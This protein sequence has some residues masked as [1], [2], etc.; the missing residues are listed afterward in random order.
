MSCL[1]GSFGNRINNSDLLPGQAWAPEVL[2]LPADINGTYFL[3]VGSDWDPKD[4]AAN[5][6]LNVYSGG[7]GGT[8]VSNIYQEY[9]F[10]SFSTSFAYDGPT[11]G[12]L[13]VEVTGNG[14]ANM[15]YKG[16]CLDLPNASDPTPIFEQTCFE[17]LPVCKCP[18]FLRWL[19][20]SGGWQYWTFQ[21]LKK[22][23]LSAERGAVQSIYE[24]LLSQREVI[25]QILTSSAE[26]VINLKAKG[27]K[28][29]HFDYLKSIAYAPH[30]LLL[31]NPE[32]WQT[33]GAQWQGVLIDGEQFV[34]DCDAGRLESTISIR[35]PEVNTVKNTV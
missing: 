30:V 32:T 18:T 29:W 20:P 8:L 11:N 27:L 14:I 3:Q 7:L 5:W 35:I 12:P 1:T 9:G 23:T 21:Y 19:N 16:D 22:T 26:D 6:T 2:T 15:F 28:K 4:P 13:T 31:K 17:V 24:P 34:K 33:E 25:K 10:S